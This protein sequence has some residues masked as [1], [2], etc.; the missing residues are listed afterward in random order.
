MN[1]RQI[2]MARHALGLTD[3]RAR[4]Y[5][6]FYRV[7]FDTADFRLWAD[8]VKHDLAFSDGAVENRLCSFALTRK[9]AGAVLQPG[10]S[11]DPEDFP[12]GAA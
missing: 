2:E 8:L 1:P 11:L 10:E 4:S 3:G 9:G 5:R 7:N 6:N 12:Q